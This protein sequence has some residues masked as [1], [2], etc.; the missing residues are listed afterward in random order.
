MNT[1]QC[2][3]ATNGVHSFVLFLYADGLIQWIRGEPSE[4]SDLI[5]VAGYST[6]EGDHF[7]NIPG[8][9]TAEI[10]NVTQTSNIGVPGMWILPAEGVHTL[11]TGSAKTGHNHK[12]TLYSIEYIG[13]MLGKKSVDFLNAS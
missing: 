2:V 13:C 3:L 4:S 6:L 10:M 8:S 9:G 5:A 12:I 11:V 1:F 7:F